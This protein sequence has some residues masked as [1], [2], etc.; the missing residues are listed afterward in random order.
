MTS[1]IRS[2]IDGNDPPDLGGGIRQAGFCQR[3]PLHDAPGS[4]HHSGRE[5]RDADTAEMAFRAAMTGPS[6]VF[7]PAHQFGA[8]GHPAPA[9]YPACCPTSWPATSSAS[10]RSAWCGACFPL[11]QTLSRRSPRMQAAGHRSAASRHRSLSRGR[12]RLTASTRAIGGAIAIMEMLRLDNDIDD[13]SA[14]ARHSARFATWRATRLPPL[15]RRR[16]A[17]RARTAPPRS[18][19][20]VASST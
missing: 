7:H 9:R 13:S 11:P 19:R 2:S 14:A 18:K 8:G 5:I 16:P 10:S 17:A 20:S 6:G 12:L 1:K 4:G 3:H 15:V